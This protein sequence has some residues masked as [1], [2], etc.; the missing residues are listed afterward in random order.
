MRIGRS[1]TLEINN[2]VPISYVGFVAPNGSDA[3]NIDKFIF[4]YAWDE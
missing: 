3:T 2:G 1:G 4:D